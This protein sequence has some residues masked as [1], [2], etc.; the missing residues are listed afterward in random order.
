VLLKGGAGADT[1][2]V[3]DAATTSPPGSVTPGVFNLSH[4]VPAT[5]SDRHFFVEA[6]RF[7][8]VNGNIVITHSAPTGVTCLVYGPF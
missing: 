7:R 1:A 8:D 6:Q 4:S 3:V 2:V 5:P